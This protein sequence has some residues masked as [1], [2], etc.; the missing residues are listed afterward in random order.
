MIAII[1]A[2]KSSEQSGRANEQKPVRRG[3]CRERR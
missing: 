1:C 2:R 3:E